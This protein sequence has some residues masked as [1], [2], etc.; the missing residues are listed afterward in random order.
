M[1][2]NS[3]YAPYFTKHV[4]VRAHEENIG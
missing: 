4:S 2:L 1:T 3:N